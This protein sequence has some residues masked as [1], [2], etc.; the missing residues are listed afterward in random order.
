MRSFKIFVDFDKEEAWLNQKAAQGQ[1]LVST[2]FGYEFTPIIPGSAVIRIDY[3][4]SMKPADY[5]DY[6]AMFADAGWQHVGGSRW[7]GGQYFATATRDARAD[8]FSDP[9]SK[10]QRYRRAMAVSFAL[11]LPFFVISLALLVQGALAI[12]PDQ[13]Y[14]TPGLWQMQGAQF[15]RAFLFETPFA[16]MRLSGPI[17]LIGA[18]VLLGSTLL[19]QWAL[20]RRAVRV[21]AS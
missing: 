2:A 13:I 1:G 16:L 14:L 9:A 10:A 11:L 8:I 20:Y 6:L 4:D 5:A 17:I 7:S 18:C 19:Y 12:T 15:W 3:R 21:A